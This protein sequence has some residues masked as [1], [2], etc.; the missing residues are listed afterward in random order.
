MTDQVESA[1]QVVVTVGGEEITVAELDTTKEI[2]VEKIYGSNAIL[3]AGYAI[4]KIDHSG[5]M[6]LKGNR[7]DLEQHL[8]DPNGVPI[9]GTLTVTHMDGDTTS[10]YELF[11]VSEGY[12]LRE[13]EVTQTMYDWVAMSK[14]GDAN[15][16]A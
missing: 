5:S 16:V 15:P 14:D 12:Q 13:G 1:A 9:P 3:P 11:V 10:W 2:D 7:K 4:K 6:A 8:F